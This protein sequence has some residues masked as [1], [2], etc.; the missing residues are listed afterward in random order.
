ME[1]KLYHYSKPGLFELLKD[2]QLKE[3]II[4][5]TTVKMERRILQYLIDLVAIIIITLILG[6]PVNI[7]LLDELL[8][9]VFLLYFLSFESI[10]KTTLGKIIMQ[11]KIISTKFIEISFVNI[12]IRNLCRIIPF[13]PFSCLDDYSFGFHDK[14]S[15][16]FVVSAKEYIRIENILQDNKN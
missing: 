3:K 12:L 1:H 9:F 7:H 10:A 13:D 16:T 5:V 15:K 2:N 4:V 6:S 8:G 11:H 14:F